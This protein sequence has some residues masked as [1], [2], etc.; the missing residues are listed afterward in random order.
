MK[1]RLNLVSKFVI[2]G[3]GEGLPMNDKPFPKT[4]Y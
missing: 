4:I 3:K 2:L 1:F